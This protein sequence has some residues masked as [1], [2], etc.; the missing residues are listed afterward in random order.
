M[1]LLISLVAASSTF[2]SGMSLG[3]SAIA[4]PELQRRN[5]TDVLDPD[6]A[7]WFASIA[8]IATPL[9]CLL[10]GPLLDKF[11][12]RVAL[13]ALNVPFLLGW[14]TLALCPS[15]VSTPVLYLGRV[16]TGLGTGMSSIPG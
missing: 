13:L 7:S 9:G 14:V 6:Q 8:S 1:Q 11:G 15:P 12:R 2:S 5:G 3:Y 4:L 16:F 10:C